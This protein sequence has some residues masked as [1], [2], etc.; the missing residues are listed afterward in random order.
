MLIADDEEHVREGIELSIDWAKFGVEQRLMAENGAEALQLLREHKP[1]V[2][3]CDMSMPEMNGMELLQR[4]REEGWDTQII[5]VSGYD[6]F[7]YTKAAIRAQGVDYILKPFRKADLEQALE[8]AIAAWSRKENSLRDERETEHRLRQAGALL[9]EQKLALYLKGEAAYHEGIRSLIYKTGL[10]AERMSAAFLLPQNRM[11]LV[12]RRFSGDGELFWFAVNNIAHEALRR[13]G[14]HYLCRIDE[15]QWVLLTSAEQQG[16]PDLHRSYI[17]KVTGAWETTLG[18]QA[19][20]GLC[21]KEAAVESLP[22]AI[23]EARAALLQLSVFRAAGGAGAAHPA[24]SAKLPGFAAQEVLLLN[25][26]KNKDKLYIAEIIRSFVQS[27]QRRG[28]LSLKE[29]QLCTSEANLMLEKEARQLTQKHATDLSVPLWISDLGEWE[30][31]VVRQ[32]WALIEEE[33]GEASGTRG[34]QPIRDYIDKH[35]HDNISLSDL[36]E[37]FHFSPQYIAKKFKELYNTTVMTYMTELRMEKA[38]SLLTHTELSVSE[39]AGMIGYADE[40]YFSKVFKKQNGV[41][42]LSYRKMHRGS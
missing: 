38:A 32:W 11:E 14:S 34:I 8:R 20:A 7:V 30:K 42:P 22:S 39:I 21:A 40:N 15:Y 19:L 23:Q 37:L 6:D 35:Y 16:S 2:L 1:A 17:G 5:V 25:A 29:L 27:L 9:D 33:G 3:F 24:Q 12:D 4:I 13:Y 31:S 36:S 41:P 10:S 28:S 18:L 26:L